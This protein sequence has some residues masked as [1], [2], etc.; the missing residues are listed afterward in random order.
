MRTQSVVSL[1]KILFPVSSKLL[2]HGL[3]ISL[4]SGSK[5]KGA[6]RQREDGR[7]IGEVEKGWHLGTPIVW[8]ICD[9][10]RCTSLTWEPQ[11]HY[12]QKPTSVPV[13]LKTWGPLVNSRPWQ[14]TWWPS[15]RPATRKLFCETLSVWLMEWV[16]V[17]FSGIFE[18]WHTVHSLRSF[19]VLY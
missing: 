12:S 15:A 14:A 4:G 1:K 11:E 18:S 8:H 6:G 5:G 16:I 3:L 19:S 2:L 17:F 7:L 10:N 9:Q 13:S